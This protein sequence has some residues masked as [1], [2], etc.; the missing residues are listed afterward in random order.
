MFFNEN[1]LR[2]PLPPSYREPPEGQEQ[3]VSTKEVP[4]RL[5]LGGLTLKSVKK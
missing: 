3:S 5:V 2:A 1:S 4:V